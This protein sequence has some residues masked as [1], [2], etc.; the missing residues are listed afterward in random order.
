M[1]VRWDLAFKGS[2]PQATT[3]DL[4]YTAVDPK[5]LN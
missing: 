4:N 3:V 5:Q 1:E 2:A